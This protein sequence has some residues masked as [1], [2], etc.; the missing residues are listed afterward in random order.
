MVHIRDPYHIIITKGLLGGGVIKMQSLRHEYFTGFITEF[1]LGVR[2]T[3]R[4]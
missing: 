4:T 1:S 2:D 3:V